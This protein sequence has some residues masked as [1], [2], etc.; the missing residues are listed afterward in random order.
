MFFL[1]KLVSNKPTIIQLVSIL[2]FWL[3]V[4]TVFAQNILNS[5]YPNWARIANAPTK[6]AEC[7]GEVYNNKLYVLPGQYGYIDNTKTGVDRYIIVP[8]LTTQVYDP[9]NNTWTSLAP[10][11]Y[12]AGISHAA[13]V[14]MDDKIWMVGGRLNATKEV[15]NKVWIYNITTN[16]W[17]AG[18]SLPFNLASGIVLKLGRKLHYFAGGTHNPNNLFQL[19]VLTNYHYV[20]NLNNQS[21]GWQ[22]GE[23]TPLPPHIQSIHSSAVMLG[24][25]FYII[26]GQYGHDCDQGNTDHKKVFRFD[27]YL[28]EWE[29]VASLP[30]AN[31]HNE[32][33]TF[34]VDSKIYSIG[35]Q[36]VGNEVREYNPATNTWRIADYLKN[37]TGGDLAIIGPIA[38]VIQ[39]KLILTT[40]GHNQSNYRSSERT[41]VKNF[42]RNYINSLRFLPD[43]IRLTVNRVNPTISKSAWL[44]SMNGAATYSVN[45]NNLPNWLT[46][47]KDAGNKVDE[48][49]VEFR[50]NANATNLMS[51]N[52]SY[53]LPV[54]A[55]GYSTTPLTIL[56]NVENQAPTARDT[57]FSIAENQATGSLVGKVLA[58]DTDANA[59]L[60]YQIIAGNDSN[61]FTIHPNLGNITTLGEL[62]SSQANY[63]LTILISDEGNLMTQIRV[64]IQVIDVNYPPTAI[65][66]NISV[67][68]NLSLGTVVVNVTASD[69]DPEQTLYYTITTGN[70]NNM[71]TINNATGAISLV[72]VLNYLLLASYTLTVNVADNGNPSQSTQTSVNVNVLPTLAPQIDVS[73][74]EL[75]FDGV[76][77]NVIGSKTVWIKNTGN[78]SLQIQSLVI[79]GTNADKFDV[80]TS[81]FSLNPNDSSSIAVNFV[82]GG[83]VGAL[84]ANLQINSNAQNQ[85]SINVGLYGLSTNGL[86]GGNEPFLQNVVNTL[87]YGINVGWNGLADGTQTTFKGEEVPYQFFK[88]ANT[89]SVG[90]I[91]VAR[92]SPAEE[93][94]FGYYTRNGNQITTH[95]VGVL[96]AVSPN[97]Q[98]LFPNIVLGNTQFD[99]GN[100]F[101]GIYNTSLTFGRT[102]Y[103]EDGRTTGSVTRRARVYPVKNRSGQLV[104]NTYLVCFED[105]T[106]GDYQ[107]YMFL[108]SNVIPD[109]VAPSAPTLSL[110][111]KTSNSVSLNWA[112]ATDNV[113]I[114]R[115]EVFNGVN[116]VGTT[117]N[118]SFTVS[119]LTPS[120][121]YDFTVKAR[122]FVGNFSIASNVL[123]VTTNAAPPPSTVRIEAETNFTK[124]T[125]TDN[126]VN[127][128]NGGNA[129]AF[130]NGSAVRLPDVGDKIRINFNISNAGQYTIRA[131]VRS[132]SSTNSTVYW[133]N[134]YI[135][136]LNGATITLVGDNNSISALSTAFGGSFYGTMQSGNR[137]LSAGNNF[138]TIQAAIRSWGIVDYIEIVPV[139]TD[140]TAP[141]AP[142][143]SLV[144]KTENS[145]SLSWAGAT[146]N[147]AVTGYEVFNGANS[148]GTTTATSLTINN[149]SPN[150]AYNFTVRARDAVGNTSVASNTLNVT[151][152]TSP[153]L[154]PT[155]IE[156]ETNFTRVTDT[157]GDVSTSNGGDATAFSNNLG[158]RL[159]DIGDKI[160][161]NFNTANSGQYMLRARVRSG[162][163]TSQTAFWPDRYIFGLDGNNI[164]F[165]GNASTISNLSSAFTGSYFGTMETA[166]LNLTAGSHFVEITANRSTC[167]IDYI[168][169]VRV[170]YNSPR[171][172]QLAVTVAEA[173][174]NKQKGKIIKAYPNP[175]NNPQVKINLSNEVSGKIN[176]QLS[177]QYGKILIIKDLN[178][179]ISNEINLDF[180]E[181]SVSKGIY[182]L[183][184]QGENLEPKMIKLIKE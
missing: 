52:Y 62:N 118:T 160:R 70:I 22:A 144:S 165:I 146:D 135:F 125:D 141:T 175:F 91:P 67:F 29:M 181:I 38:R 164:T 19:C 13:T 106:N 16:S 54:T 87:G 136:T 97:H 119:N 162:T 173:D 5:S 76:K 171:A 93:L 25:K 176:Y 51:G 180:S 152:H 161:I 14:L 130:S 100:A 182:F 132:G 30:T 112:G 61:K 115:Y 128:N 177:D 166:M 33:S 127:A 117:S 113:G 184:I 34:V 69:P 148:A 40:G 71:F 116:S 18:P 44:Y 111:S 64:S 124:I 134:K 47:T 78:S 121:S 42:A 37:E 105:A 129:S 98:S 140:T 6:K 155:R 82:P 24:G 103:S 74:N 7:S 86:E 174:D 66:T 168:E 170:E 26:G 88:K 142:T 154:T 143:L 48:T 2:F 4:Q 53:T 183:K 50:I 75:I 133:P 23:F 107:D 108:L 80:I 10:V 102:N 12:P 56:L 163:G 95:Q 49:A 114:T 96:S 8:N 99:P 39:N 9:S 46:I 77:N 31:S 137:N 85:A 156:A 73:S 41:Y 92:Y 159:P 131:R 1:T 153:T 178:Q 27:P 138:L 122:D 45:L 21:A 3:N 158:V 43:A 110:G 120:T 84:S 36:I 109:L 145:V 104:V 172:M 57:T 167:V 68:E 81:P 89:G 15:T 179:S 151:T 58:S 147:V 65:P 35:G 32:G 94:P 83:T 150:T 139:I 79:N 17:S 101:F 149:L 28:N 169:V 72:G 63:F 59:I 60:S 157:D 123:S 11:P 55:N 90:I 20:L 126:D